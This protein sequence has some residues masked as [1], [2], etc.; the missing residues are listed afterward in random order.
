[1]ACWQPHRKRNLHYS[2]AGLF[3]K[4]TPV[5]KLAHKWMGISYLCIERFKV[6]KSGEL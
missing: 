1:M 5:N 6:V 2:H 3:Q 4:I